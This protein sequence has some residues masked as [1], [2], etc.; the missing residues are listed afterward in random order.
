MYRTE[1]LRVCLCASERKKTKLPSL[2]TCY[3]LISALVDIQHIV[4]KMRSRQQGKRL[5]AVRRCGEKGDPRKRFWAGRFL[6]EKDIHSH[7]IFAGLGNRLPLIHRQI[8][9]G[10]NACV[11]LYAFLGV[12]REDR[13]RFAYTPQAASKFEYFSGRCVPAMF[14]ISTTTRSCTE[15]A[16]ARSPQQEL[17]TCYPLATFRRHCPRG[18]TLSFSPLSTRY[19]QPSSTSSASRLPPRPA[20]P[21]PFPLPLVSR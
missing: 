16:S 15:K 7:N 5:P 8:R 10:K 12:Y 21:F 17:P 20:P 9:V 3:L 6:P 18:P 11:V 13:A 1:V 4:P 19:T 2:G 14:F